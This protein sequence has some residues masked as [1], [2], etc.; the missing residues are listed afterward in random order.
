MPR[1]C[2]S[3][4]TGRSRGEPITVYGAEKVLDFTY[5]DDCVDGIARGIEALAAA[6][7][8]TRR[9]TSPIGE[10]NTLVRAAELIASR[11]G[12][13]P[14]MHDRAGAARR[15]D[16]LRRRHPQG[17]RPARLGAARLRST[18]ASRRPSTWFLEHRAAHPEEDLPVENEGAG[19]GWKTLAATPPVHSVLAIFGPTASGKTA[20][21]QAIAERIPAELVSADSMQVYRGLPILTNQDAERAARRDLAARPAGHCR[22]VPA[23]RARGD[24][25]DR[26]RRKD[27]GRRRGD[28]ALVPGGADRPLPFRPTCRRTL[29]LAGSG[30]T[31]GAA[32][33][34]TRAPRA[35]ETSVPRR[36]CTRTTAS[37]SSARSSSGEAGGIAR[38]GAPR[39]WTAETRLPTL[40][41]GLDLP[42]ET[43]ARADRR[44]HRSDVRAGSGGGG[45][46]LPETSSRR[47][48]G[49]RR[50]ST[51]PREEAIAGR[52]ARHA[53]ASRPTSASGCAGSRA[54][55]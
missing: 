11:L 12:V 54:S 28:R 44:P 1:V 45:A 21:A 55:S 38:T 29:A 26:R 37:A 25:R 20:V 14:Q 16:A 36:E 46:C 5:V 39:L 3:S 43:L 27:A 35:S 30:S 40:V 6:R 18:R 22:R 42:R 47:C 2:R 7:S 53:S 49:S 33:D 10:G 34:G 41:V 4:S 15:G 8:P 50:C 17:A 31:T 13:E 51:L 23:A 52:R 24:R 32:R 9:S 48:S 19:A